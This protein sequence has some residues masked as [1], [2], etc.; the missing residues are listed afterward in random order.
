MI[1]IYRRTLSEAWIDTFGAVLDVGGT[2]VNVVTSWNAD[3]EI[4]PVRAVLDE[5]IESR[6]QSSKSWQRWP[7]ETVANTIFAAELYEEDLGID[8]LQEFTDLYLEGFEVAKAASPGGEYC[9]RMVAWPGPDGQSINQLTEVAERLRRYANPAQPKYN[10]SSDYEI[11]LEDPALDLRTQAP[12]RNGSPYGFPCLSH[13]S[14]T[15]EDANVHLTALY[16]NQHLIKKAYGNYLGLARL[17]RALS[18]HAGLGL[19]TVTVVATHA[20][21]EIGTFAGFGKVALRDLHE[22]AAAAVSDASPCRRMATAAR[23]AAVTGVAIGNTVDRTATAVGVDAVSVAEFEADIRGDR[24]VLETMF[25]ETEIF[26]CG[27]DYERLAARFAAK[28]AALKAIGTGVRGL[29]MRDIVVNTASDGRPSLLLSRAAQ[30]KASE[31][32]LADFECSLTHEEGFAIAVVTASK[33]ART[34]A[35]VH[36]ALAGVGAPE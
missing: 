6:P 23:L 28:E 36:T 3:D 32:G 31:S 8:A 24:I 14:L 21:A 7:V 33:S 9:H 34:S 30:D 11:A 4:V 22:Q 25:T 1:S 27:G 15:V 35:L 12:G 5:F 26:D 16:R 18:H 20:S 10:Y 2:A 19:G 13:I 17:G 29:E